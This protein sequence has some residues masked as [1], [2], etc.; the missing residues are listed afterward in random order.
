M[1]TVFDGSTV[2][3]DVDTQR[4]FM[5][6]GGALYVPNAKSIKLILETLTRIA[7]DNKRSVLKTYDSHQTDC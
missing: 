6:E 5:E 3:I 4:D 2:L 1:D 7:E